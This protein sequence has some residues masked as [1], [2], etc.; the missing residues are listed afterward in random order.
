LRLLQPQ[1]GEIFSGDEISV[2]ADYSNDSR[3]LSRVAWF[4]DGS[5]IAVRQDGIAGKKGADTLQISAPTMPGSLSIRL[6]LTDDAGTHWKKDFNLQIQGQLRTM[7]DTLRQVMSLSW[8]RAGTISLDEYLVYRIASG[9]EDSNSA[10][11]GRTKDTVFV[12]DLSDSTPDSIESSLSVRRFEYRIAARDSSGSVGPPFAVTR[13]DLPSSSYV[14]TFTHVSTSGLDN[15]EASMGDTIEFRLQFRNQTRKIRSLYYSFDGA[16]PRSINPGVREGSDM[17]RFAV[18]STPGEYTV[19]TQ[20][21]DESGL[22]INIDYSVRVVS[23]PP[24]VDL[25]NDRNLSIGSEVSLYA[26]GSDRFGKIVKWEWD[27]GATGSFSIASGNDTTF[28]LPMAPDSNFRCVVR[29]TDDDGEVGS[30]TVRISVVPWK[31]GATVPQWKWSACGAGYGGKAYLFGGAVYNGAVMVPTDKGHVFDPEGDSWQELTPMEMPR[32]E[33]QTG[34]TDSSI[35]IFGGKV[36]SGFTSVATDRV[37]KYDP[38]SDTWTRLSPM[39]HPRSEFNIAYSGG[40]YYLLGG[41]DGSR[42][43]KDTMDVYDPSVDEWQSQPAP[44][45][46]WT[47]SPSHHYTAAGQGS[48]IFLISIENGLYIN[49][50]GYDI[51]SFS[52]TRASTLMISSVFGSTHPPAPRLIPVGNERIFLAGGQMSP[53][54]GGYLFSNR[55]FIYST[56]SGYWLD[57]FPLPEARNPEIAVYSQGKVFLIGGSGTNEKAREII[58]WADVGE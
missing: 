55:T 14:R 16:S 50:E 11:I 37:D 26:R 53:R 27:I 9:G 21:E 28:M 35:L 52:K 38:I 57:W 29:A 51:T 40:K 1:S 54:S 42:S 56:A 22:L 18:P 8:P 48:E 43:L 23:D 3:E 46:N 47:I 17:Y 36:A 44:S 15:G 20:L 6:E 49:L 5:R 39:P 13:V 31:R 34:T 58:E 4:L 2:A 30:D 12:D 19:A 25:G 41:S 32:S 33:C 45:G 24:V 10:P 7:V